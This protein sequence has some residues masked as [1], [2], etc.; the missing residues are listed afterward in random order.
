MSR[1]GSGFLSTPSARFHTFAG[2]TDAPYCFKVDSSSR[3]LTDAWQVE[4][5]EEEGGTK[6]WGQSVSSW[7]YIQLLS[8]VYE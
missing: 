3:W 2:F 6:V 8:D 5:K 4:H 1:S 7:L